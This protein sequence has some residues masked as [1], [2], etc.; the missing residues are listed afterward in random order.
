MIWKHFRTIVHVAKGASSW[1]T[2]LPLVD[3][4]FVLNKTE[5][6]DALRLRY[7]KPLPNIPTYCACGKSNSANHALTCKKGGFV[8]LR[9]NQ[10]RDLTIGMLSE[11]Q[12]KD[13]VSEPQLAPLS[14]E[15]FYHKTANTADDARADISCRGLWSTLD[16]VFLDVRIFHHGCPSNSN[17]VTSAVYR[18]HEQEKK[19][20]YNARI[21]EVEKATFTPLVFST[22]GGLGE[23]A[24]FFYKRMATLIA[25]KRGN[26]YSEVMA[27]MRRRL[28]FCI[29]RSCLAAIR[30]HRGK[31]CLVDPDVEINLIPEGKSYF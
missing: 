15:K 12:C 24:K 2:S 29:L 19:R 20:G 22:H 3:F 26:L 1:L 18:K 25:Q 16:K 14:G 28:R 11:A 6:H 13:V 27:F 17:Q 21:M 30:G 31:P 23:E 10:V 4:G 8:S 7:N 9:H 5:F